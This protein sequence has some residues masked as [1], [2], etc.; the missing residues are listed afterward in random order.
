MAEEVV[1][2]VVEQ[3]ARGD[4]LKQAKR[5][6]EE[7]NKQSGG[8]VS[9]AVA[10]ANPEKTAEILRL[11]RAASAYDETGNT[12]AASTARAEAVRGER[13]LANL[14]RA[15]SQEKRTQDKQ[16]RDEERRAAQEQRAE[17]KRARQEKRDDDKRAMEEQREENRQHAAGMGAGRAALGAMGFGDIGSLLSA[18][19][20]G[21]AAMLSGGLAGLYLSQ[22]FTHRDM[23]AG[24]RERAGVETATTYQAG[25]MFGAQ[26]AGAAAGN[27]SGLR[28]QLLAE[29]AKQGTFQEQGLA[30]AAKGMFN[31]TFGRIL[32]RL[33][34]SAEQAAEAND[35]RIKSLTGEIAQAENVAAEKFGA[36]PAGLRLRAQELRLNYR[37]REARDTEYT[38]LWQETYEKLRKEGAPEWQRQQGAGMAVAEAQRREYQAIARRLVDA[39]SGNADTERAVAIATGQIRG[40]GSDG[41]G[42]TS[43]IERM[44]RD[45]NAA[46]EQAMRERDP[47]H[48]RNWWKA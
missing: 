16:Q 42:T 6:A 10:L 23:L 48:G 38:A 19:P 43:A 35:A 8:R 18:G 44:H 11:R 30:D 26:G 28:E 33:K 41:G 32:P 37:A 15:A 39:R 2:I 12:T 29:Q 24:E 46:H 13:E 4:A 7:L 14:T 17:E 31:D 36:G 34:T 27:L 47:R 9:E 45:M 21:A 20:L 22:S 3:E 40:H 1:K 5:D 25:G